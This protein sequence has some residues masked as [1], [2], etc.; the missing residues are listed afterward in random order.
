VCSA[1]DQCHVPGV[2]DS[3]TGICT[4]PNKADGSG[5][6]D[7]SACTQTDTCQSGSCTGGNLVVCQALDQCHDAG[8]CNPA[9]GTCSN[10]AKQNGSGCNDGNA[11]TQTDTCQSGS[12]TGGNA[13]V[14]QPQDACHDAGTCNTQTGICSNPAKPAGFCNDSNVCTTDS[15]NPQ[16][17]CVHTAISCND[18]NA[19]TTDSC[20][21][22]A[23]CQH[24]TVTCDDGSFCTHDSCDPASGCKFVFD[25]ALDERCTETHACRSPGYWGTHAG[26]PGNVAQAAIDEAGSCLEVCG[27]VITN[28]TV[29]S[30]NSA[31]EAICVSPRGDLRLQLGR[32]L[33]AMALNCAINGFGRDCSGH[34]RLGELFAACND[35]CTQKTG[36]V[37]ECV[38]AVDCFNN[39]GDYDF[40]SGLCVT[41]TIANCHLRSLPS[42]YDG[43]VPAS[44]A[45]TCSAVRKNA[46]T[47]LPPGELSG[48]TATG[49]EL[50][51][52][53]ETCT[54]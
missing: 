25:P 46:C 4:N 41:D 48:C 36:D 11:C 54:P 10:P 20:D 45:Q 18:G 15:C 31:L 43:G 28:T 32:Q 53:V 2:C 40:Q 44:S 33:T 14:C 21:P 42:P 27:E 19:C 37:G 7:G 1:L 3:A 29:S 51:P 30:A 6:N 26:D 8:V 13:V 16:T 34:V 5:C 22:Q 24:G 49:L 39:G 35:A 23:G 50:D 52:T 38:A 9:N 47:I 12:C 17:G